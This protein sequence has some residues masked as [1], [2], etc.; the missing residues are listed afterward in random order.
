LDCSWRFGRNLR[1]LKVVVPDAF[2]DGRPVYLAAADAT[3]RNERA[4]A[5]YLQTQRR[6]KYNL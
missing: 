5:D 2:V 1:L 4:V 6:A 3:E